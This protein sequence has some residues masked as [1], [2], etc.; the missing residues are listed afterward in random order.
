VTDNVIDFPG[1][2][3]P[4]MF[5]PKISGHTLIVDGR[6]IPKFRILRSP[7]GVEF[8][9]DGRW[10]YEFPEDWAY[11][12]ASMAANAMAIGA[13]YAFLGSDSREQPFAPQVMQIDLGEPA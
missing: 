2:A 5:G 4:D 7:R 1:S 9:L 10:S 12:A 6:A 11:L 3:A 13:G 8:I